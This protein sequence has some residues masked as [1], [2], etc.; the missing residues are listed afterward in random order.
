MRTVLGSKSKARLLAPFLAEVVMVFALGGALGCSSSGKP[1]KREAAVIVIETRTSQ[2]DPVSGGKV[3]A[4]FGEGEQLRDDVQV[5]RDEAQG[6]VTLTIL[7]SE[8]VRV[9]AKCPPGSEGV[10]VDRRFTA[11]QLAENR[12]WLLSQVCEPEDF[13]VGIAVLAP[14]CGEVVLSLDDEDLGET[15]GGVFHH[16]LQRNAPG[17]ARLSARPLSD[18]CVLA[19][20]EFSLD[21]SNA[22]S[23][24]ALRLSTLDPSSGENRTKRGK[25]RAAGRTSPQQGPYRL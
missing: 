25:R 7:G 24:H 21:L 14:N 18:H 16:V 9:M 17:R 4:F 23:L 1:V 20:A 10:E 13:E 3:E 12:M 5:T 11:G 8:G 6:Q 15:K 22:R 2:G 19:Q